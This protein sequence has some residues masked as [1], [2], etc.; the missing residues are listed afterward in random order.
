MDMTEPVH[1]VYQAI[2]AGTS[3]SMV[4][5]HLDQ[6]SR[7]ERQHLL[8]TVCAMHHEIACN[9]LE[10]ADEL[11]KLLTVECP[12]YVNAVATCRL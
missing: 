6:L 5:R 1:R 4:S 9:C 7:N 10:T 2:L 12:L 11:T 8:C 3:A